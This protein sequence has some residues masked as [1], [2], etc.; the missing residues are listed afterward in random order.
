[1]I[2]DK[3]RQVDGHAQ[4][5]AQLKTVVAHLTK[6]E[7]WSIVQNCGR[8]GLE[9]WR[10]LHIQVL[11]RQLVTDVGI[12]CVR[13]WHHRRSRWRILVQPCRHGMQRFLESARRAPS[14]EKWN[15]LTTP[16]AVQLSRRSRESGE[17]LVA[18]CE[19]IQEIQRGAS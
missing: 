15:V 17:P 1:M 8:N 2:A 6:G 16:K 14:S 3:F 7:S 11:I 5:V 18:D 13:S 19:T 10:G 9:A 12:C 4:V